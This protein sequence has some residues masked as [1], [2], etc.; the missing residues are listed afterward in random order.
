MWLAS[1]RSFN[2]YKRTYMDEKT[3]NFYGTLNGL[4]L[5]HCNVNFYGTVNGDIKCSHCNVWYHDNPDTVVKIEYRDRV[6]YKERIVYK[7]RVVYQDRKVYIDRPIIDDRQTKI[8]EN[9]NAK[10]KEKIKSMRA[11]GYGNTSE[12]EDKLQREVNELKERL[13]AVIGVNH[14][15]AREIESGYRREE[16]IN[17]WETIKPTKA[18]CEAVLKDMDSF[19]RTEEIEDFEYIDRV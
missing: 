1:P 2:R 6:E 9:E 7:D 17:P 4:S 18:D 11:A 3:Y 14:E 10:L 19:K 12:K 15:L 8:L 13:N 16:E 5:T